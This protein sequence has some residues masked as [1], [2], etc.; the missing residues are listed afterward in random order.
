MTS[1]PSPRA[2]R[3]PPS[4]ALVL[5][6]VLLVSFGAVLL[7]LSAVYVQDIRTL[8]DLPATLW[9]FLC[10]VPTES[11]YALPLLVLLSL[12]AF[13]AAGLIWGWRRH[14]RQRLI[15]GAGT[16]ALALLIGVVALRL[17][18]NALAAPAAPPESPGF[19]YL[20]TPR[21]L[22]DFT[23]PGKDGAPLSLSDLE[24]RYTLLFFGYIH[25]PDICPMT[26]AEM[27]LLKSLLGADAAR[28]NILFVS[29]DGAR[30]T[31]AALTEFLDRFDS[32]FYGMSGDLVVLRQVTPDYGLSFTLDPPDP[33]GAYAVEHT[34]RTYLIDPERRLVA[35][36]AYG[37]HAEA[38]AAAL[39]AQFAAES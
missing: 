9:S 14:G 13:A 5:T 12:A 20:T 18:Q 24:G 29:V 4:L 30:D 37:T 3:T 23:L 19:T 36:I 21:L 22:A 6:V 10:G 32:S 26:L 25:C 31:P 8:R 17:F 7:L 28:V 34:T 11:A 2:N 1:L 15:A 27:R 38:I 39:D 33:S 35:S 16:A